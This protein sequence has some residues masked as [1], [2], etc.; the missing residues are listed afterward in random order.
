MESDNQN[1]IIKSVENEYVIDDK[2]KKKK[3]V[4]GLL[5]FPVYKKN[6]TTL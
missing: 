2:L 6:L 4:V 5:F 3:G 1:I